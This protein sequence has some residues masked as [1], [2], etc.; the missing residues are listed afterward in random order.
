MAARSNVRDRAADSAEAS[1]CYLFAEPVGLD[2]RLVSC[3][4]IPSGLCT[5]AAREK[6]PSGGLPCV[7]RGFISV[8]AWHEQ[9]FSACAEIRRTRRARLDRALGY[10]LRRNGR[11]GINPRAIQG[12]PQYRVLKRQRRVARVSPSVGHQSQKPS[13]VFLCHLTKPDSPL[14]A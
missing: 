13:V 9:S 3:G 1:V 11:T 10:P 4:R 12:K 14:R 7:A 8:R 2:F 6:S 5:A